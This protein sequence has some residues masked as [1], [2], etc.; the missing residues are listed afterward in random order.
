MRL[1]F[2]GNTHEE[3]DDVIFSLNVYNDLK[4][5]ETDGI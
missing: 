2:R 4:D 3:I 5:V 1:T